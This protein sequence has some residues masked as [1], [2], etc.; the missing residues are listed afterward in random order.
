MGSE[1]HLKVIFG[2]FV[3]KKLIFEL[4]ETPGLGS[5]AKDVHRLE[6]NLT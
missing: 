4:L 6:V 5:G 2:E 1:G 3:N